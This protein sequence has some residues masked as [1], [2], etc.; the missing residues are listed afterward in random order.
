MD[1][2]LDVAAGMNVA[3]ATP[4]LRQF[5]TDSNTAVVTAQNS[6]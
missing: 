1:F 4:P 2:K 6:V 3:A 5:L